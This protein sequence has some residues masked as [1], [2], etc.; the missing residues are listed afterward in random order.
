MFVCLFWTVFLLTHYV[1]TRDRAKGRLAVFMLVATLLY[2][3]HFVYFQ[4]LTQFQ[5]LSD[6]LYI[7]A[8]LSVYPLYFLYV[9]E[10]TVSHKKRSWGY[11]LLVTPP[12]LIT[13]S[14]LFVYAQMQPRELQNFLS[15][16][17][18]HNSTE[19]LIGMA[20]TQAVLHVVAKVV[21]GAQIL[22]ILYFGNRN[23]LRFE[24][25]V[26]A[27]YSGQEGSS[28]RP[29][30]FLL[31][32]FA[33]TSVFS[34]LSNIVGRHHFLDST[35]LLLLPSLL[36]SFF[37]YYIGYVGYRQRFTIQDLEREM[38][39]TADDA[40]TE[41]TPAVALPQSAD[42]KPATDSV[43]LPDLRERIEQLMRE[44]QLYLRPNL[45]ISDLAHIL[46]SNRNY[47]YTAINVEMGVSFSDYVNRMRIDHALSLMQQRPHALLQEVAVKSGFS[48]TV[49][50]YRAFKKYVGCAPKDWRHSKPTS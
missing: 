40:V 47:I 45:K 36:F 22:P 1:E 16:Y 18:Y 14:V 30:R 46:G 15:T 11:W 44:Q 27:F 25:K 38:S 20:Y 26:M 9:E 28:L 2:S 17:L 5:P 39:T 31:L 12:F 34:F 13:F 50:F 35:S 49:S 48:S 10:L 33:V 37:L 21:F 23:I 24:H 29:V 43:P 41:P 32:L 6:T 3:G 7:F 19:G 8:N 4:H 42:E